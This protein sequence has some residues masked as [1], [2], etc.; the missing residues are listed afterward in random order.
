[1]EIYRVYNGR[2]LLLDIDLL[3]SDFPTVLG[4]ALDRVLTTLEV[5][6]EAETYTQFRA[7]EAG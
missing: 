1:M 2:P 4:D 7:A 6:P 5:L 3:T